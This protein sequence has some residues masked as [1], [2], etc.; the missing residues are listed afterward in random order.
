ME[1]EEDD[2][3]PLSSVG[4]LRRLSQDE[5]DFMLLINV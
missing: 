2:E 3:S 4:M 5:P 1:E